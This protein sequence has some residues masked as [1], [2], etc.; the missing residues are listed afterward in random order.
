MY[1]L[2]T[3]QIHTRYTL[4]HTREKACLGP[5]EFCV[6]KVPSFLMLFD[7]SSD[8]DIP[9]NVPFTLVINTLLPWKCH[10]NKRSVPGL[11]LACTYGVYL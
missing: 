6:A 8:S 9:K 1:T 3:H 10:P 2:G 7:A 11:Y 5:E 4:G